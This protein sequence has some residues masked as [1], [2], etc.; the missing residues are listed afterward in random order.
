[1]IYTISSPLFAQFVRVKNNSKT[2]FGKIAEK[3]ASNYDHP[4]E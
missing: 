2:V 4:C 1:M 3:A